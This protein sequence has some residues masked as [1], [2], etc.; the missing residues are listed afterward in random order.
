MIRSLF[1]FALTLALLETT[2]AASPPPRSAPHPRPSP[3]TSAPPNG[4]ATQFDLGV[5]TVHASSLDANFKTGDFSTP[6]KVVMTRVGGDV[7]ADRANG[8]Y[9]KKLLYLNGHVVMHDSQGS[10]AG[11]LEGGPPQQAQSPSTLTADKAQ[12]DGQ[13]KLYKAIGNVHYVQGDTVVTA[14]NGTLN[15]ETH[16][17]KLEGSVHIVEGTRSMKAERV[18]YNTTSGT[19]HAQGDVTMQ[20]PGEFHRH[21]ATPKPINLPKNAIT[22][23]VEAPSSSP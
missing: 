23:P 3:G 10:G 7:T 21:L 13:A 20:F 9:K 12:I 17:L 16:Q 19:A 15:D 4:S 18:V 22:Q 6:S 8:N 14:D 11:S 5:W 2:L 1:A